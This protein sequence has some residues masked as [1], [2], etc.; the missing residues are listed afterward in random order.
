MEQ[1]VG[2]VG[3]WRSE[4]GGRRS[5]GRGRRSGV[6]GRRGE[7][8]A[9][10]NENP[11][12]YY[13]HTKGFSLTETSCFQ[14]VGFCHSNIQYSY[15]FRI[16]YFDIRVL[17]EQGVSFRHYI[18]AFFVPLCLRVS[19]GVDLSGIWQREAKCIDS[20]GDLWY[21]HSEKGPAGGIE[22]R[23]SKSEPSIKM[24]RK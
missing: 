2:G 6:G 8:R 3:G 5:E 14:A 10:K 7:V 21:R 19:H 4:V 1:Y 12:A 23:L 9:R 13:S 22:S 11:N 20:C 24:R 17:P 18:S 16:S 15:L